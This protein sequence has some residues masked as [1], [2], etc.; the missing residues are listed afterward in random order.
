MGENY[1][2]DQQITAGW[3]A[4]RFLREPAVALSHFARIADAVTNPITLAR[5]DYWQGRAAEALGRGTD[6]RAH[7]ERPPVIRPPIT[8]SWRARVSASRRSRCANPPEPPAEARRLEVARAFEILYAID[9][10]DLVAAMAVEFAD[11]TTDAGALTTLAR[12]R[13]ASQRRAHRHC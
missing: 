8:A 4:L 7:Y 2:A 13:R 12:D 6:A 1:R 3:I 10:R 5:S 11:K 9:E